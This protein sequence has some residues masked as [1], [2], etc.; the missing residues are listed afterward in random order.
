MIFFHMALCFGRNYLLEL[1]IF[2]NLLPLGKR[3]IVCDVSYNMMQRYLFNPSVTFILSQVDGFAGVLFKPDN[4]NDIKQFTERV[5]GREATFELS[6][7]TQVGSVNFLYTS[8][9]FFNF[10]QDVCDNKK[11]T[12][13][14]P[15]IPIKNYWMFNK[16]ST[17]I[18][19][20]EAA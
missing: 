3:L 18:F 20:K 12:E 10:R 6:F 14:S 17:G 1:P 9:D 15:C 8:K 2:K 5:I 13:H 7:G 19:V 16:I 4:V 11:N